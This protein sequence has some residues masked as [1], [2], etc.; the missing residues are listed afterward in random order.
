MNTYMKWILFTLLIVYVVSPADLMPGPVDDILA[1][2]LYLAGSKS[3]QLAI[4]K[5]D[6]DQIEVVDTDGKEL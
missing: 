4:D 1:I 5:R 6:N 3:K 2:L